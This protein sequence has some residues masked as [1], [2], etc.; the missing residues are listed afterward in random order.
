MINN[1][2]KN[3]VD[4]I[5]IPDQIINAIE[6]FIFLKFDVKRYS[7]L[8]T[9]ILNLNDEDFSLI[10]K[11]TNR[12]FDKNVCKIIENWITNSKILKKAFRSKNLRISNISQYELNVRK[13]LKPKHLDI[14]FRIV[15]NGK[16]DIGPP[17]FDKLIWDQSK[18][19]DAEVGLDKKDIRWKLWLPLW[20]TNYDNALQFVNG[21]HIEDVPWFLDETRITQTSKATGSKGSPSISKQWLIKNETNFK[22]SAWEIGKGVI[23]HDEI[24]HRGPLNNSSD[25]RISAEFTILAN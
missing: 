22:P 9:N 11:K 5:E 20:G 8:C 24:V 17:H 18:G 16:P 25:L 3:G 14:F 1:L 2:E 7:D 13:D 15:R 12:F 23:F 4:I 6:N 10:S 21:S 19:T